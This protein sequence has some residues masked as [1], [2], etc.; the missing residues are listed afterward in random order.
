MSSR[1]SAIAMHSRSFG[2]AD[3]ITRPGDVAISAST[4][5][6][7]ATASAS[8]TERHTDAQ[9]RDETLAH[10]ELTPG[11]ILSAV[12]SL[13]LPLRRPTADAEQLRE[14]RVPDRHRGRAGRGKVLPA[15]PWATPPS[16]RNAFTIDLAAEEVPV[17]A[18]AR[19][20][21]D[22]AVGPFRF[23]VY[24][25]AAFYAGAETC[26][27]PKWA[28]S[29]P[30]STSSAA[31]RLRHRIPSTWR[32]TAKHRGTSCW[33]GHPAR[34]P[35]A[36]RRVQTPSATSATA[37][38][39][40]ARRQLRLRHSIRQ[41]ARAR[42]RPAHRRLRHLPVPPCRICECS[43]PATAAD[44]AAARG[45]AGRLRNSDANSLELHLSALGNLR[46]MLRRLARA[47]PGGPG[48]PDRLSLVRSR[49]F[50]DERAHCASNRADERGTAGWRP[51]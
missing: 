43:F 23:A 5:P 29:S 21:N 10:R 25:S 26:L 48:F 35:P 7:H 33:I 41:R 31:G 8:R 19:A 40:A 15:G 32:P 47:P 16:A 27:L 3:R 37:T 49:R 45:A 17:A 11:D 42:R 36:Y 1:S 9:V 50:W 2:G 30:A 14:P 46:L 34:H 4:R 13:G 6:R 44:N 20:T 18:C 39:A 38:N 28:A 12:E 22:P 24:C 51:D